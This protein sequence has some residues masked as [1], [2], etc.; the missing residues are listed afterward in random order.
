[1]VTKYEDYHEIPSNFHYEYNDDHKVNV[2]KGYDIKICQTCGARFIVAK[3]V[4][5]VIC[6]CGYKGC[7]STEPPSQE[8][9]RHF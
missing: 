3:D 6:K 9:E 4:T 7:T 2:H 5:N 8:K 1:M